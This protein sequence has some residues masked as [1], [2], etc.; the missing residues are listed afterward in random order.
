MATWFVPL[1]F[2][3]LLIN[4]LRGHILGLGHTS[5]LE[6]TYCTNCLAVSAWKSGIIALGTNELDIKR[7]V[8][9]L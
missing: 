7:E 4:A 6:S 9:K 3:I 5:L 1:L 8:R 2:D